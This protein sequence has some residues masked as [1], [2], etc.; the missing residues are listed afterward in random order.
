[1]IILRCQA[2]HHR[3]AALH[4]GLGHLPVLAEAQHRPGPNNSTN[5]HI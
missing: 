1:M 2:V 5:K 4:Q 3:E